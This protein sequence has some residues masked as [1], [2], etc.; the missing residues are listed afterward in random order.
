MACNDGAII[1]GGRWAYLELGWGGY[2]A[3]DRIENASLM[4]WLVSTAYLHSILV[5]QN[6]GMLRL[7]NVILISLTYWLT[8]MGVCIVQWN[9][10]RISTHICRITYWLLAIRIDNRYFHFH[11][12]NHRFKAK[13]IKP[14]EK[15]ESFQVENPV[16]I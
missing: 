7:W 8:I 12:F 16:F 9:H 5:E 13:N 4:P 2:W 3:W 10:S 6:K 11:I 15:I 1:L 14:K